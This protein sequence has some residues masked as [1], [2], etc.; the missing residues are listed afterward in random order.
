MRKPSGAFCANA[1]PSDAN[2]IGAR[3]PYHLG[4][5]ARGRGCGSHRLSRELDM[6]R[7]CFF[8]LAERPIARHHFGHIAKRRGR[9][10]L[11]PGG[12]GVRPS[13]ITSQDFII[14]AMFFW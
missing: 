9:E 14:A 11:L 6:Q 4:D 3:F 7:R 13:V 1:L 10:F 2:D 12:D 5:I 8:R